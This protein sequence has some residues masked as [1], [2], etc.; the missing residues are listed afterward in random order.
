MSGPTETTKWIFMTNGNRLM[1]LSEIKLFT[2]FVVLKKVVHY[3]A[4]G[5]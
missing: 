5:L 1:L 2:E 4:T 3:I